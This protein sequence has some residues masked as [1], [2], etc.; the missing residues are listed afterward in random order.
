MLASLPTPPGLAGSVDSPTIRLFPTTVVEDLRQTGA[1]AAALESGVQ[2]SIE[3]LDR[4]KSLYDASQCDGSDEDPGCRQLVHQM[5]TTYIG[6]LETM[7]Q[8]LPTM[9]RAV[10]RTRASLQRRLAKE[11]GRKRTATE[12]QDLLLGRRDRA[13]AVTPQ[14]LQRNGGMRLSERFRRYHA[15]VAQSAPSDSRG[16]LAV[17]ASDIYLDMEQAADLIALTRDEINRARLIAELNQTLTA[18]T[19]EMEETITGVKSLLFGDPGSF[20][21]V[22][23]PPVE[24]SAAAYHSPLEL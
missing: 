12:I 3:R 15:L 14:A 8:E 23:A 18:L 7:D 24:E 16:S 2:E 22:S 17:V 10:E 1:A 4:Q 13:Q 11:L 21:A 6:M 5:T 9:E 20:S 19:P